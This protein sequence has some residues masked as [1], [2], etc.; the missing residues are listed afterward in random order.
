MSAIA[1]RDGR[2]HMEAVPLQRIA[3][4]VGTPVYCYSLAALQ[5]NYRDFVAA[6][7]GLDAAVCYAVKANSNLAIIAALARLGAGA[8]VVS[9]GEMRRAI[10]AGV[11][12]GKIVFSGVGKKKAEMEEALAAGIMQINVESEAEL[13][14]LSDVAVAAGRTA[15]LAVRINPDVDA[16]THAKITTGRK[17]N[18]FGVDYDQARRV[19]AVAKQLPGLDPVGVAV[20]I[21]SQITDVTPYRAAYERVAELVRE[22]RGDGIAIGRVDLGGGLGIVYGAEKAPS[23]ADYMGIVRDTVG[24][25]GCHLTF[26]PGRW[27]VG[28]V[29]VLLSEV[30]YVKPGH[31]RSF[32]IVDAAMNDLI[33]PT[34][35]EAYHG[36]RPVILPDSAAKS[37]AS[38]VVGPICESG[39]YLAL[40]R[41]LPPLASGDLIVV[42]SAGAY[43]AVMSSTYNTRPLVPEV[44]VDGERYAVIR[45][46]Q[47]LE[48]LLAAD[49]V[50]P[51]LK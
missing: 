26:E 39:D 42:E 35:Y 2:L 28:N 47:T 45:P 22:L 29:G 43:G 3:A 19:Y 46:R 41:E 20:H 49:R 10:A 25:L 18:K 50:P 5:R 31:E 13:R 14:Q 37:V 4:E 51:W 36:I 7:Q 32:V 21:G 11:P 23:L 48:E 30:I 40:K 1:Y 8:D 27:M 17:E 16:G 12:A 6:A 9:I 15:T 24:G 34:L 38:D 33:R 44:L